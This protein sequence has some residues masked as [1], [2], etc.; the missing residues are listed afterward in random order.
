VRLYA[1]NGSLT[2]EASAYFWPN[3]EPTDELQAVH[4]FTQ[5]DYGD[6]MEVANLLRERWVGGQLE[7]MRSP[8][9][10]ARVAA[11][12][13]TRNGESLDDEERGEMAKE[14]LAMLTTPQLRTSSEHGDE[15]QRLSGANPKFQNDEDSA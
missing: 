10:V 11:I 5:Q 4:E 7:A 8:E 15:N 12:L 6:A 13:K 2:P 1:E 9:T 14:I 3:G